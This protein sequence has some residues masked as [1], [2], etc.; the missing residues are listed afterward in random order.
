[1]LSKDEY[2]K[3]HAIFYDLWQQTKAILPAKYLQSCDYE[4]SGS[5]AG[6]SWMMFHLMASQGIRELINEINQLYSTVEVLTAL[7][8]VLRDCTEDMKFDITVEIL[9]PICITGASM[10][11]AIKN[12]F[13]YVSVKLLR[14]MAILLNRNIECIDSSEWDINFKLLKKYKCLF[15]K[16]EWKNVDPF[17]QAVFKIHGNN[18]CKHTADFRHRFQHRMPPKIEIGISSLVSIK[19]TPKSHIYSVGERPLP[20]EKILRPLM[21]EHSACIKA[22]EAFWVLLTEQLEIWKEKCA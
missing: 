5:Y 15:T 7:E 8:K 22:F 19:E 20:I 2:L 4:I 3:A 21:S 14:E 13:I 17:L 9:T 18:Y 10:P 6:G 1:M 11:Y 16:E 12:R